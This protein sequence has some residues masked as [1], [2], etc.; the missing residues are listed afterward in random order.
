M[1][2]EFM[3]LNNISVT[4]LKSQKKAHN[5]PADALLV[6]RKR[7]HGQ[8]HPIEARGLPHEIRGKLMGAINWHIIRT[9]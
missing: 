8:L 5:V 7:L 4:N 9:T 1:T 3:V 6:D 2:Q